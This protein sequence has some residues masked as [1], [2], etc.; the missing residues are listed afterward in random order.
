MSYNIEQVNS[1]YA[2]LTAAGLAAGTNQ[3]R[4]HLGLHQQWHLQI[5][6]RH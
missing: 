4:Q 6:E 2:S 3:D 1:G 5:E